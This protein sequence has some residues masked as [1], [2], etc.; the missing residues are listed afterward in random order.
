[1][2]TYQNGIIESSLRQWADLID[3]KTVFHTMSINSVRSLILFLKQ[4]IGFQ[5]MTEIYSL[6]S[7]I[8]PSNFPFLHEFAHGSWQHITPDIGSWTQI[9]TLSYKTET[10]MWT[11]F[12]KEITQ[13]PT[14][15]IAQ[16]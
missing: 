8:K 2:L 12:H 16:N 4:V 13:A 3:A 15:Y 6:N 1:M 10:L 9:H 11:S 7:Q 5:G 14:F